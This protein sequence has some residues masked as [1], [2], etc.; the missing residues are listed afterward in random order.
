[1][2]TR[3][4]VDVV[5][6]DLLQPYFNFG[7]GFIDWRSHIGSVTD[8]WC[9]VVLYAPDYEIDVIEHHRH[10]HHQDPFTPELL[11]RWLQIF[12]DTVDCGWSG[13]HATTAKKRA[14]GMA[15]VMASRFLGKRAWRPAERR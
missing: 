14:A 10:L 4:Y 5:Q 6:D 3:Q 9:H 8:Y 13:P 2:V 11:D 7:P 15:W 12:Y 1:M